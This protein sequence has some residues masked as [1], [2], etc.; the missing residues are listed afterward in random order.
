M[1]T[2][3]TGDRAYG[4]DEAAQK[5]GTRRDDGDGR[6]SARRRQV[7]RRRRFTCASHNEWS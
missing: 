6:F 5:H 1:T 7:Y 2:T 4:R 3:V